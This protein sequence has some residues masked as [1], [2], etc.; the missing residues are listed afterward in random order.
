MKQN[1]DLCEAHEKSLSEVKELK[2]FQGSTF[3]TVEELQNCRM[4]SIV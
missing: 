3:D 4:Q 2:R 1:W